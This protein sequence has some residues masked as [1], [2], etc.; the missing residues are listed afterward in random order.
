MD[1][2]TAQA[3][4]LSDEEAR[5]RF[6]QEG[7]NELPAS[8]ERG[9]L[10]LLRDV[11]SEPMFLLLVSCGGIYMV[12]GDVREALMLLGFVLVVMSITFFQ[13]RRTERSLDALR[14]LSSPRASVVRSGE[15]TGFR[16]ASWF[17]AT[18]S[19]WQ[20][21]TVCQ[22]TFAWSNRRT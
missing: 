21:A 6:E 3:S 18:L 5:R 11:A 4:G 14:D 19:C 7:P 9:V 8:K 1:A 16:V 12:L 15:P 17:V 13:E 2:V 20:K 22:R 10:R